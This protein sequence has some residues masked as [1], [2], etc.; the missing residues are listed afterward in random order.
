M[1]DPAHVA[2]RVAELIGASVDRAVTVPGGDICKAWRVGTTAGPVFAKTLAHAPAGFFATEAAGL[3][4]LTAPGVVPVPRVLGHGPD[5]LVL[6]WVPPGGG[7]RAADIAFGRG[8][9]RVHAAGADG[10]GA[11]PPRGATA[12][13][14]ARLGVSDHPV[15]SWVDFFVHQRVE[16]LAAEADRRG[17]LPEGTL[18][19][20]DRLGGRLLAGDG[21]LTG[22]PEPP[23]RLHGD[24]WAG[25]VIRSVDG[26]VWLIDPAAHGG[27]RESDLAMMRLFGGFDESVFDAYAELVPLADGWVD[28][29]PLHQLPPLLVHACLFGGAYGATV[30]RIVRGYL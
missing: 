5:I 17:V 27:H 7:G 6:D 21:S 26:R 13:F 28:R 8:L 11:V 29:V 12:G 20:L 24:L 3:A 19:R 23:A 18:T 22:P 9:A 30:D 1:T 25:N 16:P 4:W 10:F 14:L 15:D 2:R